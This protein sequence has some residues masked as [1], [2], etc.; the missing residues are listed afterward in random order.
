[1]DT[2]RYGRAK[3]YVKSKETAFLVISNAVNFH[4]KEIHGIKVPD[5]V[6]VVG[7]IAIRDGDDIYKGSDEIV[8]QMRKYKMGESLTEFAQRVCEKGFPE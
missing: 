3:G 7:P 2:S 5:I 1:L 8:E 4:L 6:K